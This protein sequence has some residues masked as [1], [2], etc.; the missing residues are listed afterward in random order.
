MLL[1]EWVSRERAWD[2]ERESTGDALDDGL[3]AC[4]DGFFV[5]IDNSTLAKC[6]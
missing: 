6:H 1:L 4:D 2:G 3:E 5:R